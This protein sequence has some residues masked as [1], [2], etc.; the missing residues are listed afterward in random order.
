M[1]I[2][3]K[4]EARFDELDGLRGM[5]ILAAVLYHYANN[6][7]N[8]DASQF[9]LILKS[10]THFFYTSI[11]MFFILSGFL[12]GGILLKNKQS[13]NF[14]KTFYMR[15]IY[16]IVPLYL[17]LLV[18]VFVIC[19]LGI[20]KGTA[21]WFNPELPFWVYFTFLQNIIMGIKDIMGNAWLSPTWSLGVEEQFYLIISFLIYFSPKR[22]LVFVLLIGF[23][24]APIFRYNA[25]TVYA[26][27][28]FTYCRFDALFGGILMAII[29]QD[30]HTVSFLKKHIN[31]FYLL[32][33]ILFGFTFLFSIGKWHMEL[34]IVNTWF[35]IIYMLVLLLVLLDAQNVFS[36]LSRFQFFINLGLYS[37]SIYLFHEIILGLFFFSI[38]AKLPQINTAQD[39]LMVALCALL[40]FFTARFIY[41]NFEKK[42]MAIGHLYKY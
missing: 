18:V 22:F 32:T 36:R 33:I 16:R 35:S 13:K 9:N 23:I 3:K 26:L 31:K 25:P 10:V 6:L 28:T 42:F 27:S 39:V 5:A 41:H 11:D 30:A 14:F 38:P 21:W 20:G 29:Y 2:E 24:A 34:F 37:F 7:I 15:R 4:N 8:A 17:L 40:T 19:S 1:V 12:L